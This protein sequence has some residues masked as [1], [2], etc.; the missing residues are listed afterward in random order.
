M[1][2]RALVVPVLISAAGLLASG[3]T[4]LAQGGTPWSGDLGIGVVR[5]DAYVRG[6]APRD[7]VR[8]G[9]SPAADTVAVLSGDSIC[10]PQP[11]HCVR[12]SERMVEF[13]YE[14]AGWAIVRLSAD[15]AWARVT[16]EPADPR[17]PFGWV[18]LRPDSVTALLWPQ[19]LLEQSLFFRRDADIAFYGSPTPSARVSPRLVRSSDSERS[20]YIMHPLRARGPWLQVELVTPSDL[21]PPEAPGTTRDTVWIQYLTGAGRPTVFFYTRGC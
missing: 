4:V 13:D 11:R 15:S 12:A 17:G 5:Y 7:V 14:I 19:V 18:R 3:R 10:L 9:P 16:L 8:A 20:D 2:R 21:C 6:G 1:K